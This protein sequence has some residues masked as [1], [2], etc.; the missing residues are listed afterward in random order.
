MEAATALPFA[1]KLPPAPAADDDNAPDPEA[2][3]PILDEPI[4][5]AIIF[6]ACACSVVS[7]NLPGDNTGDFPFTV[8]EEEDES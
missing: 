4:S 1:L 3:G 5:F 7:V 6:S 8:E 2:D